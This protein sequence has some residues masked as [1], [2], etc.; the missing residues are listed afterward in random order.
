MRVNLLALR[1]Q[2]RFQKDESGVDDCP[3]W[4]VLTTVNNYWLATIATGWT[5]VSASNAITEVARVRQSHCGRGGFPRSI[6][7][8]MLRGICDVI[9]VFQIRAGSAKALFWL[10]CLVGYPFGQAP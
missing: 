2:L 1:R 6:K 4:Y 10:T 9:D 8:P 3:Q 5:A 7:K